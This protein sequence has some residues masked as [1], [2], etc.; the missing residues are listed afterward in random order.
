MQITCEE[1][2]TDLQV[3]VDDHHGPSIGICGHSGA[4]YETLISMMCVHPGTGEAP[5]RLS[6]HLRDGRIV[7]GGAF[8]MS[9]YPDSI[10]LSDSDLLLESDDIDGPDAQDDLIGTFHL[11]DITHIQLL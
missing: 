4:T 1:C 9:S 3:T 2:G 11:A 5:W 10:I 7:T 6:L 8:S